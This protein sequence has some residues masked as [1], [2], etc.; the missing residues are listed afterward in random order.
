MIN[1]EF[2]TILNQYSNEIEINKSIFI[3]NIKRCDSEE[4][5]INFINEISVKYKDAN[6]NCSAYINGDT[7]IIQ[8][9]NDDGEPTGTAGIPMLEVL[10]KEE[11]T[12]LCAV[13]TR[14]FGGKKLGAPGLI[15]AYG[16]SVSDCLKV[17]EVIWLKNFHMVKI[18]FEY[19]YLG[20][21]DNF[22]SNNNFF[23]RDRD[24]LEKI[25]NVMYISV[26][27]FDFFK[28]QLLEMT[29]ANID[30]EVIETLLLQTKNDEIII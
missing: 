24:Y 12:N 6:H 3:T 14:Y 9:Y 23:I 5:S 11:L 26:D 4:D 20:K 16:Q 18:S 19:P 1:K 13:V 2:K 10:K 29:S 21:I 8:R 25:E 28:N 22:I 7:Q 30:I 27:E 17:S 15:R